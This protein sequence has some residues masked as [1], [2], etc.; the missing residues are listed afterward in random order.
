[1]SDEA[2]NAARSPQRQIVVGEQSDLL[3]AYLTLATGAAYTDPQFINAKRGLTPTLTDDAAA[4]ERKTKKLL[5]LIPQARKRAGAA[6]TPELE[7]SVRDLA[8]SFNKSAPFST[9]NPAKGWGKAQQ[10]K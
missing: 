7:K 3:D 9:V 8:A 5:E 1:M 10:V 6:W 4:I 2:A